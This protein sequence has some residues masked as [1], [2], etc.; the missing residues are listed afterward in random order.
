[1]LVTVTW[2]VMVFALPAAIVPTFTPAE[3]SA[4]ARGTPPTVTLLAT[5]VVP[6]GGVSVNTTLVASAVPVALLRMMV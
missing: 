1:M 4:P 6:G 3:G 5:K 2:K